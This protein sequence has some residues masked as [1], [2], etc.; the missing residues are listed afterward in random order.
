M[1]SLTIC[2]QILYWFTA[3]LFG[4]WLGNLDKKA[5]ANITVP[6]ARYN[7]PGLVSTIA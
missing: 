1:S 7:L 2:L 6:F 5:V 3:G 4:Y